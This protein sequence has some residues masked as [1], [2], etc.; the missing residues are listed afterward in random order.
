MRTEDIRTQFTPQKE[1]QKAQNAQKA[2]RKKPLYV[3]YVLF[4][5]FV[6]SISTSL[7][8]LRSWA[9]VLHELEGLASPS[10]LAQSFAEFPDSLAKRL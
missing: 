4:V 1:P 6:A 3:P 8:P 9:Q 2:Q 10:H 5:P 7:Q